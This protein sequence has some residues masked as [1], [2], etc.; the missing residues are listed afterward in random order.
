[1]SREASGFAA[2]TIFGTSLPDVAPESVLECVALAFGVSELVRGGT[3]L[4]KSAAQG[5]RLKTGDRCVRMDP[6]DC[7]MVRFGV[8]WCDR[9]LVSSFRGGGRVAAGVDPASSCAPSELSRSGGD[10]APSWV[11]GHLSAAASG[12]T[13]LIVDWS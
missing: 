6:T 12:M 3:M 5:L 11:P 10:G 2:S 8:L 4:G 1:M 7:D 9:P 13:R